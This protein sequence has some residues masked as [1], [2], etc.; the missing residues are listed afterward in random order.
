MTKN[1]GTI[2]RI[3]RAVLGIALI[4]W[5]LTGTG[6]YAWIGWL[7]VVPLFTAAVGWCPPYSL[8]GINT[9]GV[10]KLKAGRTALLAKAR[11]VLHTRHET[12]QFAGL[13]E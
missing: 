9:C 1:V 12:S 4:A 2:D 6:Q 7:G 11:A 5:A 10:K 13:P 8:L 3:I